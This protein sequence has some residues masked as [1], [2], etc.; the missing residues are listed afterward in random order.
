MAAH[1][2]KH[3]VLRMMVVLVIVAFSLQGASG[4]MQRLWMPAH[5]HALPALPET[6]HMTALAIHE[7]HALVAGEVSHERLAAGRR[8]GSAHHLEQHHHRDRPSRPNPATHSPSPAPTIGNAKHMDMG[9]A[10]HVDADHAHAAVRTHHHDRSKSDVVLVAEEGQ[11]GPATP[12]AQRSGL[13]GF[14]SL[15][16]DRIV[17]ALATARERVPAFAPVVH[18]PATRSA[19]ERPPRH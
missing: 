7:L 12:L 3:L 9:G 16:P 14:W 2:M 13:D 18:R 17:L 1:A 5:Y 6:T 15:L 11:D 19:P 8:N 10:G 4:A